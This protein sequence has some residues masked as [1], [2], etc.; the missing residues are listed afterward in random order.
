MRNISLTIGVYLLLPSLLLLAI[1]VLP[2]VALCWRLEWHQLFNLLSSA[3]VY[4]AMRISL[5]SSSM[6]AIIT[7][8][9]GTPFAYLLSQWQS[10]WKW[11]VE[12]LIDLPVVLPPSAAG[13]LLL[14]AFGRKGLLSPVLNS[15]DVRLSFTFAALVI[16]QLFV[17]APLYVRIA[18]AS[19]ANL[20]RQWVEAA[21]VEG[22]NEW[23][24]F[25]WVFVPL[26]LPLLANGVLLTWAR[27][28]GEFGATLLFAGNLQG[29]TQTLPM[30]IYLSFESNFQQALAL[31]FFLLMISALLLFFARRLEHWQVAGLR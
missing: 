27:A 12:L 16:A 23:Q 15:F 17:A 14:I 11:W 6:T 28:I 26:L 18:R 31:S 21:K 8:L 9:L 30:A 5:L 19:F 25:R 20:D 4:S 24:L 2:L 29:R 1:F 7:I 10:R 13:L 22:A 3:Q